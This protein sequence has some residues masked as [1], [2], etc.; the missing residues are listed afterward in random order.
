MVDTKEDSQTMTRILYELAAADKELRFSPYCWRIRMALAHKGLEVETEPWLFTDKD[1]LEPS[2][3]GRVPV[4]V[5]GETWVHDSWTIARYLEETYPNG[6][7][8]FGG[9]IGRGVTHFLKFWSERVLHPAIARMIVS[10]IH[11]CLD[12]RD[13]GYFRRTR[14]QSFGMT[15]EEVTADREANLAGF[16][17]LLTPLRATLRQQSYLCGEA[18][19]FGDYIV[20]G[21]FQWARCCSSFELLKP[22]DEVAEWRARLLDLFGGLA[23]KAPCMTS[24]KLSS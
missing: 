1:R 4:L 3:Q 18:P 24:A 19:G 22:E 23:A 17:E 20:F 7:S 2:G 6:P 21:A 15:L 5:D 13:K 16:H 10:D 12:E 8:L 11:D 14:E 9:E